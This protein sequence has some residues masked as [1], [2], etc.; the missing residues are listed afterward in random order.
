MDNTSFHLL[1]Q[2]A[3]QVGSTGLILL[4][5][6]YM[7][8][9]REGR[10][11][12]KLDDSQAAYRSEIVSMHSQTISTLKDVAH[13]LREFREAVRSRPCLMENT[14]ALHAA[15]SSAETRIEQGNT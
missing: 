6:V 5:V 12:T 15:I 9:K 1:L 4:G 14:E 7:Q 8:N 3:G 13:A 2:I 11:E 10:L